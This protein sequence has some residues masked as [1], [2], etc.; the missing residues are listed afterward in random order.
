MK[1]DI[2]SS[3]IS[4]LTSEYQSLKSEQAMRIN[5]RDN[6]ISVNLMTLTAVS[7]VA[8]SQSPV[9]LFLLL[10]I[11]IVNAIYYWTYL[12]NDI[13]IEQL[14]FFFKEEFPKRVYKSFINS[15]IKCT[16]NDINSIIGGWE[17]YHRGENTKRKIRKSF[18]SLTLFLSF[19]GSSIVVLIITFNVSIGENIFSLMVWII[20]LIIT[21]LMLYTIIKTRHI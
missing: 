21:L 8:F 6:S 1:E 17:S 3:L 14:R 18:N 10:V 9:N 20:D 4:I 12:N 15:G 11:P 16:P 13:L 2:S 5:L 19:L 7:T